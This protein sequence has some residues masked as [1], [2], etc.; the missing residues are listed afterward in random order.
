MSGISTHVLDVA[1][2]RPAEGVEVLL[3]KRVGEAWIPC[4]A[5]VTNA[6]GR[7]SELLAAEQVSPGDL[8]LSF[9]TAAYFERLGVPAFFPEVSIV[10][11]VGAEGTKYHVPL[12]LS[13]F[14]YST[15]RGS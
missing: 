14:G 11:R 15:Y 10:F 12:L 1:R 5:A 7:C 4:G 2:G 3:E 13:P 6:D 8:R 9:A